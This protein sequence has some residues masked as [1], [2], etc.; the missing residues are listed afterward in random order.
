MLE[1]IEASFRDL[2][3][4][5][6]VARLYPN[7]HP[8]FKKAVD[9]AYLSLESVLKDRQDLV[10]GIIGEELAYEKEIFFDL[11]KTIKPMILYL[12]ERGIERIEF[13]P[14][15]QNEELNKFIAFLVTP[16]EQIKNEPQEHLSLLGIK[17]IIVSKIKVSPSVSQD[18]QKTL[19]SHLS[20]YEDSLGKV[21]NSLEN[22]LDEEGFDHL[23]LRYTINNV[24]ENLLGRYQEFLTFATMKRYDTRT[25]SHILNVSILSMYFSS[26]LGFTKE[27]ILE[28]GMA[29]LF[30]D[31]GK[32]YISRKILKKP[33][34]LTEEEFV[35]IKNHVITGTEILLKFQDT[36]GIL[37]VVVCFEHHLRY[38]LKGYPKVIFYKKPHIA[39][40]IV[41][42]CDV[43]DALFQ[44][45][46]Y[47]TDY[48]PRM[49]YDLMMRERGEAF[50]PDLLDKFFKVMG[51][52][53]VGTIVVLSDGRIAVVR[54]ENEDDIFSPKIEV[55]APLDK[56]EFIDLKTKGA[57]NKIERSLNPL[58]EGRDYLPLIYSNF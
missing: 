30:H 12:K 16:K 47:K 11:S 48:P 26:K 49:I 10:I 15:L 35:K 4:A 7:W 14:D 33:T 55:I 52:W 40:M 54:Q 23:V 51:V 50:E 20:T 57:Q 43:Y 36:L 41:S 19:K 28:I 46:G 13:L 5:I 27:Q 17:N 21:T 22:V 8:Y 56:K 24:I 32:I 29:A 45:R 39:S 42:I 18:M 44:R 2:I 9:K 6:Q 25:F 58:T 53:P 37:P 3:S 34:K 38:N 1:K 31:I